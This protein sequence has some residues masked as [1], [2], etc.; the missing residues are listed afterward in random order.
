MK[1]VFTIAAI[2]L[3]VGVLGLVLGGC[4]DNKEQNTV[5]AR[6]ANGG[7][8]YGGIFRVNEVGEMR[9]L[10]PTGINDVTSHHIAHQI[11]ENLLDLDENLQLIPTLAERWEVST[12]GLAY[13]YFYVKACCSMTMNVFPK[14]KVVR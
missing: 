1:N 2:V 8:Q 6:Q 4:G 3:T 12:D 14:A 7:K 9:G 11:Y 10:D 13:T 5:P